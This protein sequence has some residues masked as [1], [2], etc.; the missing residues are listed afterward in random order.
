MLAGGEHVRLV[1]RTTWAFNR[2]VLRVDIAPEWIANPGDDPRQQLVRQ[3]CL[4][5]DRRYRDEVLAAVYRTAGELGEQL[6]VRIR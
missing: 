4:V 1:S 2:G 3:F 5:L 6:G